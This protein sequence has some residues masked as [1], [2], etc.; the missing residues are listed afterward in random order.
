MARIL[1][2]D[3]DP[4]VRPLLEAIIVAD[5]H[6]VTAAESVKVARILLGKQLFDLLITDVNLPDGS[7]LELADETMAG[8]LMTLVLTG[9]GR[10]LMPGA[11]GRY[12][13]LL[14]PIRADEL[15]G[16]IQRCLA[17]KNGDAN[18]VP[19]PKST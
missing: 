17:Q 2:V 7:G 14:K 18:I 5:G 1:L 8:G 9:H 6:H 19:F 13:Y 15:T 4:D 3:D 11:L 12:N 16:A 10:K